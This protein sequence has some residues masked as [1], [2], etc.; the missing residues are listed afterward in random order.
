[1]PPAPGAPDL[2]TLPRP[3]IATAQAVLRIGFVPLT[4][5]APLVLAEAL[6]FFARAGLRVAL[7]AEGAW[8]AVRDKLSFGALDAAHLLGPMPIAA[9]LGLAGAPTRRLTVAA[10]LGQNGNTIVLSHALA[11]SLG[12]VAPPLAAGAFASAVRR[13]AAA[14][15]PPP[16]LAVVFPYSSHNY[17]L[18]HWLAAGGLDPDHDVRLTVVPP[19]LV[20]QALAEGAIDGFCAGEPWGSAAVA[21]GAGQLAL[22]TGDIWRHHPEKVLA[23]AEGSAARAPEAAVA[24]AVA[25][26]EAARWLEEPAHRTEAALVLQERAFPAL[27]LPAIEA[28]LAGEVAAAPGTDVPTA[29]SAP[30]RFRPAT[31]PDAEA[32]AW[33]F[34]AMRRWGHLPPGADAEAALAPWRNDIWAEAAARL[35]E[36]VPPPA[37]PAPFQPET[38]EA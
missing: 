24:A 25:V 23:F 22:S 18:R 1:M 29:L 31:R 5:A 26:I 36:P 21:G 9:A 7:S 17:L 8:A 13:R 12:H 35:G 16:V 4:D 19:P 37:N 33:F 28:A 2:P 6:G 34:R 32:A 38:T 3:A 30:L 15:A 27:D 10:G 14:G 11:E 20:A